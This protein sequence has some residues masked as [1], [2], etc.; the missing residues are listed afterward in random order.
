MSK[1]K[2][3]FIILER[4]CWDDRQEEIIIQELIKARMR[5]GLPAS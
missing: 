4:L 5:R 2:I 1:I 3:H